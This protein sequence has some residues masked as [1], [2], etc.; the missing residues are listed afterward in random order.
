MLHAGDLSNGGSAA[1]V[2]AQLSWLGREGERLG[3]R[4]VVIAG[5]HDLVLDESRWGGHGGRFSGD[6]DDGK[7]RESTASVDWGKSYVP[8]E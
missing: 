5:N 3:A 2:R 6:A 8:A 1:E 4:V 7:G